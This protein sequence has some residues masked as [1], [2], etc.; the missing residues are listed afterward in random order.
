MIPII[1][2]LYTTSGF[3]ENSTKQYNQFD[4]KL[5]LTI[6]TSHTLSGSSFEE[7][8]PRVGSLTLVR[9]LKSLPDLALLTSSLVEWFDRY[10]K[11]GVTF[12]VLV[13][14]NFYF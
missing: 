13:F 5:E 12:D 10:G 2:Q 4:T 9:L 6:N 7:L 3:H 1:Q 8:L 14:W 11:V